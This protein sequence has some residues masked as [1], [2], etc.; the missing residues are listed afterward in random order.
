MMR[1]LVFSAPLLITLT[2][3]AQNGQSPRLEEVANFKNYQ[4]VGVAVSQKPASPPRIFVTFPK[5]SGPYQYGLAEIVNG[6]RQPYPNAEW[7]RWDS[8]KPQDR[9]M[10][11]QA[12][13]IDQENALWVL[14]PAN[15]NDEPP[16]SAGVKLLKI[17]LATNQVERTY[18]FEDLPREKTGLNDV[19]VDTRR[20]IAYLSDPKRAAIVVLDLKSGK[21]RSVLEGDKS[22]RDDPEFILSIDG[23]EVKDKDGKAFRSNVNGIALTADCTYLYYRAITQT[24]LYRIA[25]EYL[26]NPRLAP[27]EVASHVETVGETGVSHGMIADAAGNVYLTDSQDKAVRRITP[28]GQLETLVRDDRLLWPDSF[29][30]GADGYLYLTAAQIHR[31]RKYNDGRDKVEYPFRLYRI[32]L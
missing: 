17:N 21:S 2:A 27:A 16:I 9:F 13:L 14:D 10:N 7:N 18:R 3:Q 25:T 15:P 8:L 26:T 19:R 31:T 6:Q 23:K 12:L 29:A 28:A 30:V 4:L 32:K 5:T 20:Q 24:K 1:K 22:T 11:V